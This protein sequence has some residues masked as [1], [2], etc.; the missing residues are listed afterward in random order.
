MKV[1]IEALGAHLGHLLHVVGEHVVE[2][3]LQVGP[4][5][6]VLQLLLVQVQ[7]L[8][9]TPLELQLEIRG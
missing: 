7:H 9:H 6:D 2:E 1:R 8:V 3:L 5:V 4:R